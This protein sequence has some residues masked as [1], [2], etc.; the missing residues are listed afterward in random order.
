MDTNQIMSMVYLGLL[1]AA[2]AGSYIVAHRGQMGKLAQQAAIWALIFVG[3]IAAV[4]LWGDISRDIGPRQASFSGD[5]ITVPQ[6]VDGH[7]YLTLLVNGVPVE[8]VVD[9]GATMV[10][11]SQ[12]D[13]R[14]V[15]IDPDQL[16]YIGSA[17]TANGVVRTAGV[18]LDTVTLGEITDTGVRAVVNQGELEGSLLGM[19][20]LDAFDQIQFRNG[21]LT[22]TR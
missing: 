4:G 9:T 13:A 5:Q 7:Y 12:D 20:Y 2:I 21:E 14:Q 16:R 18:R 3:V 17:N 22:L 1:G 10:V 6:S 8:F 19:S 15:G 11:L